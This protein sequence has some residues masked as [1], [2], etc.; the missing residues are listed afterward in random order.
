VVLYDNV[1]RWVIHIFPVF[2]SPRRWWH[3]L[4]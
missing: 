4:L 3:N 1:K 2:Y